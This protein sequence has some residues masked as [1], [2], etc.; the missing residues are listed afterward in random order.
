MT[1]ATRNYLMA[2]ISVAALGTA[3]FFAWQH[4]RQGHM[5][6]GI[7]SGN[8]RIEAVEINISTK[9]PG[10]LEQ[11]LVAEGDYVAAGQELA[12]MD[13][14][15]LEAQLREAQAQ[16]RQVEGNVNSA[17]SLVAQRQA[18]CQAA[19]AAQRQREAERSAAKRQV[20][21]TEELA[22]KGTATQ[23][24][25]DDDRVRFESAEAAVSAAR[26]N[27]AAAEAAC[28]YAESQVDASRS[29]VEAAAATVE[30]IQADIDDSV[31]SSP[32]DGRIQYR[33]AEPGEVVS[34][35]APVLNM[36][37]LS[38]VY[39]T[40]F[41]PTGEAGRVPLG[42][43]ARIVLDAAPDYVLPA[44]VT[45]VSDVAQFTPKTVETDEERRKLMFR[46]K[47]SLDPALLRDYLP[48]VKTGLPGVAYVRLDSSAEW[49]TD[50]QVKLPQ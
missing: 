50:L 34:A 2:A 20:A 28:G 1:T 21:R 48:Y 3:A 47:V 38:D 5:P 22:K 43:E 14:A 12:K 33:I 41:L 49:P 4:Y 9:S 26:A 42:G 7:A 40:F 17:Q 25:L 37:A 27:V 39:M 32:R 15:V 36:V 13:T 11:I 19:E 31:L 29:A 45:F 18:E 23:R 6:G 10:R 30:R 24:E 46:I 44:T 35:G 16:L 8:G